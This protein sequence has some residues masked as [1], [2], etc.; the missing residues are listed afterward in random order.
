MYRWELGP[1]ESDEQKTFPMRFLEMI[2][3]GKLFGDRVCG[4][5]ACFVISAEL[6]GW[7]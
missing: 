1:K 7:I 6:K 5:S 4:A 3:D 2:M